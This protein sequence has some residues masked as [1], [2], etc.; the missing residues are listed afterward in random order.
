MEWWITWFQRAK[1]QH[2]SVRDCRYHLAFQYKLQDMRF[3]Y[4]SHAREIFFVNVTA[5]QKKRYCYTGSKWS[6]TK[7]SLTGILVIRTIELTK[8]IWQQAS[9][10]SCLP[11]RLWLRKWP[12]H[13]ARTWASW[14]MRWRPRSWRHVRARPCRRTGSWTTGSS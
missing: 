8:L 3:R 9:F 10:D 2:K 12:R 5:N 11:L 13:G 6:Q 7:L 4:S 14:R 1:S